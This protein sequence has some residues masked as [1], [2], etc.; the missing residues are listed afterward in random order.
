MVV[1]TDCSKIYQLGPTQLAVV[2]G[3]A[4]DV[5]LRK[6]LLAT[7]SVA[8]RG[9]GIECQDLQSGRFIDFIHM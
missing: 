8:D 7:P 3:Q 1:A 6:R 4:A 9:V 5:L 2:P